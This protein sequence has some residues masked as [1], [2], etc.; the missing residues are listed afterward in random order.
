MHHFRPQFVTHLAYSNV[1]PR[2][3]AALLGRSSPVISLRIC[4]HLE[5]SQTA[6]AIALLDAKKSAAIG[7]DEGDE[8]DRIELAS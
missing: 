8:T 6:D 1:D 4:T 2:T 5:G 3:M 7:R